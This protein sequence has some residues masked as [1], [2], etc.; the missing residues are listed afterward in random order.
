MKHTTSKSKARRAPLCLRLSDDER[1]RLRGLADK[2][3]L[4]I[5]AYIRERLFSG[6]EHYDLLPHETRQ[7]LLAQILAELGKAGYQKSL[8]E[9]SDAA[10]A[11]LLT[12]TPETIQD[13][14]QARKHISQMHKT[15]LRALG[16][17]PGERP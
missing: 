2:A 5:S 12:L 10:N 1:A 8:S 16:L 6:D 4:T 17:R 11:G 9:I 14:K 15:L 13:I 7:K 3:G